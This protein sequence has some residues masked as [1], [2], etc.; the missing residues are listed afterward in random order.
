MLDF[1]FFHQRGKPLFQT[2]ITNRI[3][4]TP[5]SK[6]TWSNQYSELMKEWMS[7]LYFANIY[8][9]PNLHL[10]YF[11]EIDRTCEIMDVSIVPRSANK[12]F[13]KVQIKIWRTNWDW[14][15]VHVSY[16]TDHIIYR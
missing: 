8:T 2:E 12:T 13:F 4:R 10:K 9:N 15:M 5:Q 7:E 16:P 3:Y 1:K 6:L 11:E 14:L